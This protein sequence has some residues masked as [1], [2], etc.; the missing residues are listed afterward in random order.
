MLLDH[1]PRRARAVNQAFE[2]GIAGQAVGAVDARRRR[3]ARSVEAF[4]R[5][6]ALQ[7]RGYAPHR[8]VRRRPH[9]DQVQR[10]VNVKGKAGGIDFRE[11][12]HDVLGVEARQ[13]EVIE[14]AP[15]TEDFHHHGAGNDVARGKLPRFVVARHEAL[16]LDVPQQAALAAQ[17]LAEQKSRRALDV[18]RGGVELD[19]LH[20]GKIRARAIRHGH[21]V[22][23]GNGRI[24]GFFVNLPEPAG[25][26]QHR[27]GANLLEGLSCLVEI[28]DPSN[29]AGVGKQV[30]RIRMRADFD[31][32]K[33][34]RLRDQRAQDARSGRIALRVQHPR[35]RVRAFAREGQLPAVLVEVHSPLDELVDGLG[36]F[37]DQ[38]AH[39]FLAAEAVAGAQR[40]VK[41]QVDFVVF[42]ERYGDAALCVLGARLENL[43]L[44]QHQDATVSR[45]LNCS[46]NAGNSAAED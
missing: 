3:F 16:E 45:Q 25:G 17:R 7:V 6:C 40:V 15:A 13:V 14:L 31:A 10:D 33:F 39:G 4:Q 8:V 20:V 35:A 18:K 46:S 24:R 22:S 21:A 28:E 44:G 27:A 32:A 41:M 37:F 30:H 1:R 26:Q 29:S 11:A 43:A 23:A 2:K 34:L 42:G 38:N 12:F 36:A 19:K 5:R 9:R